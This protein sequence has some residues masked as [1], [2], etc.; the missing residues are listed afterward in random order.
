MVSSILRDFKYRSDAYHQLQGDGYNPAGQ[1]GPSHSTVDHRAVHR[2]R[3]FIDGT[4][5]LEKKL[6]EIPAL[7]AS[8]GLVVL[9]LYSVFRGD[10]FSVCDAEG[11][12]L[13]RFKIFS[14]YL[15]SLMVLLA[16]VRLYRTRDIM[17]RRMYGYMLASM[18]F[19]IMAELSATA[20]QRSNILQNN[21]RMME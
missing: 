15:I 12:G 9:A 2:G 17:N 4:G 19:T 1:R 6:P 11:I 16:I 5:F 20:P 18:V 8:V 7:M 3:G 14:E 13:T 10:F 21:A